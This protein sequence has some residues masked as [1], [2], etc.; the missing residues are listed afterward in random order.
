MTQQFETFAPLFPGFYN[1]IFEYDN[2]EMDIESYN[3]E[4]GTELKWEDF[5]WD[6]A[7]Y[8][9][10]VSKAFVNRLGSE[11]KFYLPIKIEFQELY[12]PK[13][14]NFTNDSINIKVKVDLKELINLIKQNKEEAAKY[15][16]E[17]YTSYDGFFSSH[18]ND[19][20]DW[21]NKEY[22]LES[23]KYRVGAL[24]EC[25]CNITFDRE[26]I[27][28]WCDSEYWINFSPIEEIKA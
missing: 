6:Y 26:D 8:R 9:N 13:E 28:Y 17:T 20:E 12:N 5:K 15:F 11:L 23:P 18:S 1:T 10:R 25:F 27:Y 16:K 4:N 22:I 19:I 24:L 7:E 2:E 3:E 21:L 14:Y